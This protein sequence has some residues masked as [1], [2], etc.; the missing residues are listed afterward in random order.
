MKARTVATSLLLFQASWSLGLP[1]DRL[2]TGM[3]EVGLHAWSVTLEEGRAA[4]DVGML[5]ASISRFAT[6]N[7]SVGGL[8]AFRTDESPIDAFCLNVQARVYFLPLQRHT[9]WM[10]LRT[11]GLIRPR[12]GSGATHLAASFGW[13][14]RPWP[15]LALDLQIAGFERW[16]YDDPSEYTNGTSDWT[17][18]KT[19]FSLPTRGDGIRLWLVPSVQFLF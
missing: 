1:Q 18:Q 5:G 9:P 11:G 6:D 7:V 2:R 13:R 3:A 16:G 17:M 12:E 15:S 14:W 8:L 19:P 10:E 4:H